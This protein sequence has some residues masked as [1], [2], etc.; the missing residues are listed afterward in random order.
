[1]VQA[2]EAC[3]YHMPAVLDYAKQG[4]LQDLDVLI[5]Q[6]PTFEDVWEGNFLENAK[7][8]MPD[9]PNGDGL[10]ARLHRRPSHPLGR[11]A[12]RGLGGRAPECRSDRGGD[13]REG[14][15]HDRQ[16]PGQNHVLV[17]RAIQQDADALAADP[18]C[19]TRST[20]RCALRTDGTSGVAT[21]KIVSAAYRA[22]MVH[23][24]IWL[25]AST[26]T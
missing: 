5:A 3:I 6:D 1:M 18:S 25:P 26:T 9:N 8:W 15:G 13:H 4:M 20:R 23:E 12:V 11:Q 21:T 10:P 7:A 24:L 2:N 16:E 19:R 22:A 14:Q 17:G